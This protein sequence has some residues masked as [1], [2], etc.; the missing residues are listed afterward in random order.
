MQDFNSC[1]FFKKTYLGWRCVLLSY[2]DW[3]RKVRLNGKDRCAFYNGAGCQL[4]LRT[5]RLSGKIRELY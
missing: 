1:I 4:L 3:R 5:L 2:E